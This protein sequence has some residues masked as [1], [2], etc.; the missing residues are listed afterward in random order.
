MATYG[1]EGEFDDL[2]RARH[3]LRSLGEFR[4][5]ETGMYVSTLRLDP[6][7]H[8]A[9]EAVG[10]ANVQVRCV[11]PRPS[12]GRRSCSSRSG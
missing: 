6:E 4:R 8:A 7:A 3:R 5:D 12:S 2:H 9:V 1:D 11:W 10:A